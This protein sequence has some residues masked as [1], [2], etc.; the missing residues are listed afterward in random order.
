M[1]VG[2]KSVQTGSD[3]NITNPQA[4]SNDNVVQPTR[5]IIEDTTTNRNFIGPD[6]TSSYIVNRFISLNPETIDSIV[7]W[8]GLG[9]YYFGKFTY[10]DKFGCS[11][12]LQYCAL[13]H[14]SQGKYLYVGD[15][16]RDD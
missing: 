10:E 4:Q 13:F 11:H 14:A 8:K 3:E 16:N 1:T 2:N 7:H 5:D 15:F 9:L 12:F 6:I